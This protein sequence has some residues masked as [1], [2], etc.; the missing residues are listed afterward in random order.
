MFTTRSEQ[1]KYERMHRVP[2]YSSG[3]GVSYV[4]HLL[5][6]LNPG[7]TVIDFGC[8]SGD[9]GRA[10]MHLGHK[11]TLID[12]TDAGLDEGNL[13]GA[14][15][16]Q[17][18]LH[19][20]PG[21]IPPATWGF[22]CDVMEHLPTEWVQSALAGMRRLV[23]NIF[24]TISGVPDGWGKHIGEPLHLTVKSVDWWMERIGEHWPAVRRINQSDCVF[25]LIG[26]ENLS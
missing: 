25:E 5:R 10:L 12:I 15:F 9:A 3:P 20:L 11:V 6:Y 14:R 26:R 8:G 7:D 18:S 1:S 13:A 4:P 22:C 17:A 19:D 2:G 16:I 23:G 24:F 21:D